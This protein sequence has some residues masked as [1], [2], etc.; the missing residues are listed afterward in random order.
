MS[1]SNV[2]LVSDQE[3]ATLINALRFWQ[4]A[5]RP[6]YPELFD[7]DVAAPVEE[8]DLDDF[9]ERINL[10]CNLSVMCVIE[11]GIVT[12]AYLPDAT[13][14]ILLHV[15]DLDIEGVDE[16]DLTEMPIPLNGIQTG[17]LYSVEQNIAAPEFLKLLDQKIVQDLAESEQEPAA[18]L[19]A[20]DSQM[21]FA[22]ES[23]MEG[24]VAAPRASVATDAVAA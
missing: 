11:S 1:D 16:E 17:M 4:A 20:D 19:H 2:L 14:R 3:H 12:Q 5:G 7:G 21:S 13:N 18:A 10:Q 6:V 22:L 24:V 15:F 9:I 23:S 8:D